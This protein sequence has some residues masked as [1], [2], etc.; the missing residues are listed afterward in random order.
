MV[1][2]DVHTDN[3]AIFV[4]RNLSVHYIPTQFPETIV[5]LL[6][7]PIFCRTQHTANVHVAAVS[8]RMLGR[9]QNIAEKKISQ[10]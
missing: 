3:L 7:C 8:F 4:V 1:S 10:P 6:P 5:N 9:N 2:Y